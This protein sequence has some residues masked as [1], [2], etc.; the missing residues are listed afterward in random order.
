MGRRGF[1]AVAGPSLIVL[2]GVLVPAPRS[3]GSGPFSFPHRPHLKAATLQAALDA[4][5]GRKAAPGAD[6]DCRVCHDHARGNEAH[7][8]GCATCHQG[9]KNLRW[10]RAAAPPATGLRPFPHRSH[11]ADPTVTCFS[12]HRPL[13]ENDWVEFSVPPPGLAASGREGDASCADCHAPHEPARQGVPQYARTGDGKGCA[14]CHLGAAS[15][16][17]FGLRPGAPQAAK[18]AR[19]FL[20]AD[21]GGAGSRCEDCHAPVREARSLRGYDAAAATAKACASCHTAD[22]AGSPLAAVAVP[23]R[24]SDVPFHAVEG[25]SHPA[26]LEL[27]GK[28][29]VVAKPSA[30][31]RSCHFPSTDPAAPEA[32][33]RIPAGAEPAGRGEL[34]SYAA[35]VSCHAAW[36]V[37]GHGLGR[38]A[39]FKCHDAKEDRPGHLLLATAA[40]ER[41]RVRSIVL[42]VHPHPGIT[43]AGPSLASPRE[44]G[45]KECRECHLAKIPTLESRLSGKGFV[46]APHLPAKPASADCLRCHAGAARSSWSEDLGTFDPKVCLE[47]HTGAK[48]ADLGVETTR[49]QVRQFDHAAHVT[50]GRRGPEF[51]GLACAECHETGGAAG[52]AVKP[53]AADC[54]QCHSHDPKD[55]AEKVA[56]TGPKT[57]AGGGTASCLPCHGAAPGAAEGASPFGDSGPVHAREKRIHLDLLPGKQWHDLRGAAGDPSGGCAAC[58]ERDAFAGKPAAYRERIAE[59]RVLK[60][61]HEDPAFKGAWFNRSSLQKKDGSGDPEN[62]GR[63]CGTCHRE[64]PR[65]YLRELGGK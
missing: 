45:G 65:G 48:P 2:A 53:A 17:P 19:P 7:L 41:P 42:S 38:W 44:T 21:H 10:A 34:V 35:C 16:V 58:H 18:A 1:L 4:A 27:A 12:C 50:P 24:T 54:S 31:C 57:R 15:I 3:P 37:E 32:L 63:T 6:A 43:V 26:H 33:R 62:R 20:H 29:A 55:G 9:E 39:C 47:C 49:R 46:H 61:I 11:L 59:A 25:F 22:A 5:A 56:R 8:E 36:Q 30:G 13:V 14:P 23:P 52:Y 51:R 28:V 60:S 40:V 64:D